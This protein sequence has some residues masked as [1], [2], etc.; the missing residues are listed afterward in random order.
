MTAIQECENMQSG[1][2]VKEMSAATLNENTD[3][4][5]RVDEQQHSKPILL[6][7]QS[8]QQDFLENYNHFTETD[9]MYQKKQ[10][11][12]PL[13]MSVLTKSV[14][15]IVTLDGG[16]VDE[17]GLKRP[18]E[19]SKEHDS[20]TISREDEASPNV[21]LNMINTQNSMNF[22]TES[23]LLIGQYPQTDRVVQ[24]AGHNFSKQKSFQNM[25]M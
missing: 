12:V 14:K 21:R 22:G 13:N 11:T 1:T 9:S 23:S 16:K 25:S 2:T 5:V 20:D 15:K 17:P 19:S 6:Q 3:S 4:H 24:K 18:R 7:N 8:E 10:P